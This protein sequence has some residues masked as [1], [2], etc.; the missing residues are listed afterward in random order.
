MT[1]NDLARRVVAMTGSSSGIRYV[2]HSTAYGEDFEEIARRVPD[3]ARIRGAIGFE[4]KFGLD[5][6]LREVIAERSAPV[7]V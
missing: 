5:D 6:I 3:I 4:P 1:I 7:P 2:P